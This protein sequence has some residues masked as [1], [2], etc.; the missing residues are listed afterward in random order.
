MESDPST[1]SRKL[2]LVTPD[3]DSLGRL[4][5]LGEDYPEYGAVASTHVGSLAAVAISVG[6]DLT[7]PSL[8]YKGDNGTPNEDALC[9]IEAGEWAGYA[10]ADAHFGQESSHLLI[11][12]LHDIWSR[13]RPTSAEH[14]GQ[15][16]EFLRTGE[17]AR[18]Q[19]ESTLLVV[20]YDRRT[21]SGFGVSFGDSSFVIASPGR[22]AR[23]VNSH[24]DRFVSTVDRSSMLNGSTFRFETEPDD[25]LLA[26]TDGVDQCHY[27]RPET[28][29][30]LSHISE[31][32][33]GAPG[34]PLAVVD[35]L[36]ALALCGVDGNPGGQDN[37]A[38]VAAVS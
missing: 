28:S 16:I 6:T 1:R 24:D 31:I 37:V 38:I 7:S 25:M 21:R 19:S 12:R 26:F 4:R 35:Q 32:V 3:R 13:V 20:C 18:T 30:Q 23:M 2:H 8:Q 14:L 22:P 10:V 11:S 9:V 5:L 15:M 33:H 34:D 36:A 27:R 17:R 29:V